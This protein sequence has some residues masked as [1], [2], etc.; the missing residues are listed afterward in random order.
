MDHLKELQGRLFSTVLVFLL[1]ASAA[2]PFFGVVTEFL[3]APL[4][5]GQ[6]L[7][8]LTPGGALVLLLK[9]VRILG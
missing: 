3:M 1:V 6:D 5:E 9:C 7:V 4:K 8:Y 2:Y